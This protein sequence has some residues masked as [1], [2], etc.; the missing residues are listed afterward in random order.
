MIDAMVDQ[1]EE[2]IRASLTSKSPRQRKKWRQP[3]ETALSAFV[4]LV[5]NRP[6]TSVMRAV[7][8][9]CGRTG[10]TGWWL[11][12]CR[13]ALPPSASV[14]PAQMFRA[15]NESK[16]LNLPAI[17]ERMRIRAGKDNQRLAFAPAFA[18]EHILADGMFDDLNAE[19][20][21]IIDL[22][23]ETGVRLSEAINLSRETIRLNAAVPSLRAHSH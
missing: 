12:R 8:F 1:L 15:I 10:R 7:P 3:K 16:Q 19:A 21:R 9:D 23:V 18:Q 5:G 20:R 4:A 13:S 6:I 17:F 14:T 22:M 11:E 2:I